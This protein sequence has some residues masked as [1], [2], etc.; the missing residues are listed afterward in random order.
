MRCHAHIH[1]A[2][3]CCL[4]AL[5]IA[6][7]D[8]ATFSP[9]SCC[10]L[11]YAD[12]FLLYTTALAVY[13]F[14][15]DTLRAIDI[16]YVFAAFAAAA[17]YDDVGR[18]GE[19]IFTLFRFRLPPLRHGAHAALLAPAT[20]LLPTLALFASIPPLRRHA[21]DALILLMLPLRCLLFRH[22][23]PATPC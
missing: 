3:A 16:I 2:V 20:L 21:A 14:H 6:Y 7:V 23:L 22:M 10:Y 8:A 1:A 15:V 12:S 19:Y 5:L 13:A 11:R 17:A 18:R 4:L 9:L